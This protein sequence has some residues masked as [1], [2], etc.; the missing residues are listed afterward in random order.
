MHLAFADCLLNL[1]ARQLTRAGTPVPLEPKMFTLLEVLI[2]R[3]P[4]VVTYDELDELLWPKVY[5]ARTSLT[6]LVSELRTL[7]GDDPGDAKIIRTVYKTG[8][9]FAADVTSSKPRQAPAVSLLLSN[10]RSLPLSEGENVAG[11]DVDCAVVVDATTVSRRHARFTVAAGVTTVE[12]LGSTNGTFVNG[13]PISSATRLAHGDEI[14][15][16]KEILSLRKT[17]PS[18]PTEMMTRAVSRPATVAPSTPA[19][20][21]ESAEVPAKRG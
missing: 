1:E 6:R 5:V 3:C 18:A 14:S 12:D 10:G 7:L 2:Q 13:V 16:G 15:L 9:A 20:T 19:D 11:R 8:Y 17:A 4:A 21:D